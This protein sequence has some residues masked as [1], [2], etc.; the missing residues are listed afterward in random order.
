[1]LID[2]VSELESAGIIDSKFGRFGLLRQA[3][4]HDGVGTCLGFLKSMPEPG[5]RI[6]GWTCQGA[7]ASARRTTI[8]CML[9]RLTLLPVGHDPDLAELFARAE[10]KRTACEGASTANGATDWVMSA[11]NPRLRGAQ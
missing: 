1:M 3:G 11:D 2:G 10:L 9:N 7:S 8:G 6:S 5:L 4:A